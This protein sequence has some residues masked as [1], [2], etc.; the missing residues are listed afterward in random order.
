MSSF[1]K[2]KE[3]GQSLLKK[4]KKSLPKGNPEAPPASK[5]HN[6]RGFRGMDT[7]QELKEFQQKQRPTKPQASPE[8]L[9]QV[10]EDVLKKPSDSDPGLFPGKK[11]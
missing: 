1:H 11:K 10:L 6:P 8:D 7:Q 2:F 5:F 4:I 3:M 9:S